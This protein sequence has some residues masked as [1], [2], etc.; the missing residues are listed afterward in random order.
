MGVRIEIAINHVGGEN[1][2]RV[3]IWVAEKVGKRDSGKG[4][5][6]MTRSAKWSRELRGKG[7]LL[8]AEVAFEEL[9]HV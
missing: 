1:M 9:D 2:F 8:V 3:G 4:I 7:T 6:M 5:A